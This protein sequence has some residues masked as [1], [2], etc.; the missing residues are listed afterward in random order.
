VVWY[1]IG[2]AGAALLLLGVFMPAVRRA[3]DRDRLYVEYFVP[4]AIALLVCVAV[5]LFLMKRRELRRLALIGA[6]ALG[7][8]AF[9][10]FRNEHQKR[11]RI[12]AAYGRIYTGEIEDRVKEIDS[13]QRKLG[14]EMREALAD[15]IRSGEE[16]ERYRTGWSIMV[17]GSVLL[18]GAGL[19]AYPSVE[20]RVLTN[21]ALFEQ[22]KKKCPSCAG[23][24]AAEAVRCKHCGEPID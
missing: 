2:L 4:E 17:A 1:L 7:V 16:G 5:S 14:R 18:L 20:R 13:G 22:P 21:F 23:F 9:S 8:L 10:Y 6:F 12:S 24:N 3:L 11:E 15:I 19:M